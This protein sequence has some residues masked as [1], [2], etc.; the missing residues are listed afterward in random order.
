MSSLLAAAASRRGGGADPRASLLESTTASWCNTLNV[1]PLNTVEEFYIYAVVRFVSLQISCN[2]RMQ[3]QSDEMRRV[4]I[5]SSAGCRIWS[6]KV[7]LWMFCLATS[8]RF[9]RSLFLATNVVWSRTG[10]GRFE[11]TAA[12]D[13]KKK[14]AFSLELSGF[15]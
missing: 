9:T 2:V 5:G 13:E 11:T 14:K 10:G 12:F 15:T 7:L 1:P 3:Y 8:Q 4:F 6:C